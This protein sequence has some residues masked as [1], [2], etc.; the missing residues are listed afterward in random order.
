MF[1]FLYLFGPGVL[2]WV[3]NKISNGKEDDEK[4]VFLAIAQIIAY[5][6]VN[7]TVVVSVLKP[8][9]KIRMVNL[10]D[11]T[12]DLQYGGMALLASVVFAVL[13]GWGGA[14]ALKIFKK[15]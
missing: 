3:V 6:L 8:I 14:K 12:L 11:G 13:I 10:A 15:A 2:S 7:V 5:A 9:G 1:H 4:D